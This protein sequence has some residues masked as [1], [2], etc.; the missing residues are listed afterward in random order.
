VVCDLKYSNIHTDV[1]KSESKSA[2]L[3]GKGK[4]VLIDKSKFRKRLYTNGDHMQ[5]Q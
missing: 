4:T 3:S 1:R 5:W 2:K